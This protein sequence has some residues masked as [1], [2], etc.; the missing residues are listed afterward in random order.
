MAAHGESHTPDAFKSVKW[1]GS[2]VDSVL[3]L[4][5]GKFHN[6]KQS[7]FSESDSCECTRADWPIR[8]DRGLHQCT[9]DRDTQQNTVYIS[10]NTFWH[11]RKKNASRTIL[12]NI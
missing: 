2:N 7:S 1:S 11:E 4:L 5:S 10:F 9:T 12:N 6:F 8:R 3:W